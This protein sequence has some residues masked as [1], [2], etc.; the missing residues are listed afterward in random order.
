MPAGVRAARS[1][2]S[3]GLDAATSNRAV[4]ATAAESPCG[5]D[6]S[7]NFGILSANSFTTGSS[8]SPLSATSSTGPIGAV[9]AIL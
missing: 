4:S 8:C 3:T 6:A 9:I 7:V 5:G 2:T 1:A